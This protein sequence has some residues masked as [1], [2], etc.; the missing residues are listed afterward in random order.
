MIR[1]SV[2]GHLGKDAVLNQVNGKSVMN[3]TMAHSEKIKDAN[4]TL[5]D[6]TVWVDCS[7]WTERTGVH[8]YLKKGIQIYAEGIPDLR[9]Y[10]TQDGRQGATITLRVLNV[11]LLSS[12]KDNISGDTSGSYPAP[13]LA[14]SITPPSEPADDLPF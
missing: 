9:T 2:I 6:K 13:P 11:Q 8:P 14:S 1:M 4:G 10:T 5:V 7:Y 3:F 12:S